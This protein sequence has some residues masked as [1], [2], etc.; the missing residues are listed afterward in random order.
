MSILG[1]CAGSLMNT[2]ALWE[3]QLIIETGLQ[4]PRALN[5]TEKVQ[6]QGERKYSQ[7]KGTTANENRRKAGVAYI[8]QL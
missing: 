1:Y 2:G 7:E 4:M 6:D 8:F 3:S 5:P